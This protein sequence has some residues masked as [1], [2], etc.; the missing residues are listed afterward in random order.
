MDNHSHTNS[1]RLRPDEPDQGTSS[2]SRGPIREEGR[3]VTGIIHYIP[4]TGPIITEKA[5]VAPSLEDMQKYVDGF[6][7]VVHILFK[8]KKMQMIVN[9]EGLIRQLPF[10]WRATIAYGAASITQRGEFPRSPILGNAVIFEDLY[11]E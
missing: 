9:E 10:N 3:T 2:R 6:V 5:T 11:W 4:A 1:S 8:D 7:E